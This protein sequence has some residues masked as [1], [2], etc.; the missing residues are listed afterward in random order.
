MNYINLKKYGLSDHTAAEASGFEGL[1]LGRVT[2]Q[3]HSL[4]RVVTENGEVRASVSGKFRHTAEGN[5]DFPAVGDWV[6]TDREDSTAGDAVIRHVLSRRSLF[7][8]RAAGTSADTQV[9]AANVDTLFICMS[10]NADF[11]LRRLERYLTTAWESRAKPVIVLTKADL[12]TD[13]I[14]KLDD[15]SSVSEGIDTVICSGVEENG[16]QAL[17][18][19]IA[20][21]ETV[22]FIGSSGVGKS[23]LIN[24]LMGRDVMDVNE[25]RE[26]DGRGRHTTTGRHLLLLPQGGA[27]IDTPGMRE[28]HL[29]TGDTAKAFGDIEALAADCRFRDC[30]HTKEPGC[31]VLNA[32]E[33]GSLSENRLKNYFKLQREIT[34][35]S[36]NFRQAEQEKLKRMFGGKGEMKQMKRHVK[37][38]G[39]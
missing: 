21:S 4:Y 27:V 15:V 37:N 11:N 33:N 9:V 23:T 28:L 3:S 30:T 16:W 26:S 6:M 29:Y 1:F 13:L 10:L 24:R 7:V 12:C 31:A 19:L 39:K 18:R 38:K 35:G 22:A 2:W 25:I 34:Y 5:I 32:V 17:N 14:E 36:L 20:D 8:R